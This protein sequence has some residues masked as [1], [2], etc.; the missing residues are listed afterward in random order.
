MK[1]SNEVKIGSGQRSNF[2]KADTPGPGAYELLK[3]VRKGVTIS[4]FKGKN[5]IDIS[6]GPGAYDLSDGAQRPCS[7]KYFKYEIE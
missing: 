3:N 6:P 1:G 4:G 5:H 2:G 7:A